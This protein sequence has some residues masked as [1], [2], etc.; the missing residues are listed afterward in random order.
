MGHPCPHRCVVVTL[1]SGGTMNRN[2]LGLV[3]TVAATLL[4]LPALVGA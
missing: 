3:F 2:R 4:A 1:T